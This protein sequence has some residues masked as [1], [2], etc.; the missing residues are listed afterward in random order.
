M[1][2][3][4]T[5][6]PLAKDLGKHFRDCPDDML[7]AVEASVINIL[8]RHLSSDNPNFSPT[9]FRDAIEEAKKKEVTYVYL[10]Q[11]SQTNTSPPLSSSSG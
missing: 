2:T 4:K 9:R 6:N 5:Y 1:M 10:L 7:W 3:K 8:C 11:R